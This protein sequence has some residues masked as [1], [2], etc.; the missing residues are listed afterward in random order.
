VARPTADID[1][2]TAAHARLA[3]TLASVTDSVARRPSLLPG[4][5]A[6]HVLTHL[7]RNADSHVRMLEAAA[8]GEV[9]DQYPGG[10]AQR[11]GDIEAGSS[12]P[13]AEL[14]ADV[15]EASARLEAAWA[16][17]TDDTWERGHGRARMGM[18]PVA[19]MPFRRWREVE[20]HHADLGLSYRFA[21]W[22]DDY[23]DRELPEI[24]AELPVR[25]SGVG[26]VLR[27]TD[28]GQTWS[29]P[30]DGSSVV[31]VVRDRRWLLAWLMGRV[32][33]PS[34]PAPAPW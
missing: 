27:V 29:V 2:C 5:T 17:T 32:D 23:V 4:W 26:L 13:A 25:L 19:D 24:V 22:P 30:G 16:A 15:V 12:R 20:V 18:W 31:E 10:E 34:L 8:R 14:V 28:T 1:G 3:E 6:G 33:E 7:A 21:D 9:A 11:E